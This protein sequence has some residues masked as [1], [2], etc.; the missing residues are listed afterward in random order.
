MGNQ[1]DQVTSTW[2]QQT[3]EHSSATSSKKSLT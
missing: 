2:K 3:E 1:L